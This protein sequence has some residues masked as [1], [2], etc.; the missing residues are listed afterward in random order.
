[1]QSRTRRVANET[2]TVEV[3]RDGRLRKTVR[4]S[5]HDR[6]VVVRAPSFMDDAAIDKVLDEDI[7]PRIVK[8]RRRAQRQNDDELQARAEYL[9]CTYFGGEL[10]WHTIRWVGNMRKRL[11]SFTSGGATDGDIRISDRMKRWPAYVV[12]YVIAHEMV[13]RLYPNHS[14]EFWLYLDRYILTERAR[15]FIEGVA[16][17]AG[18]DP[19]E[20]L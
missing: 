6:R 7:I 15:G 3:R 10:R 2:F 18:E 13:H 14:A 17:A 16:F 9:N 8:Q 12:D 20:W 1:M 11:G 4:W 5:L 19:E